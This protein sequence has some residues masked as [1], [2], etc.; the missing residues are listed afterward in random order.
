MVRMGRWNGVLAAALALVQN[1][2]PAALRAQDDRAQAQLKA[3]HER[4]TQFRERGE[5]KKASDLYEQKVKLAIKTFG[6]DHPE[7]ATSLNNLAS[8]YEAQGRYAEA[9]PLYQRSL[10][11][12]EAKLGPDHPDVATSLN[13]LASLYEKQGRYAEAEPLYK[14]SL[15]I[16]EAKLGPDHPDVATSLNNLAALYHV[17]GPVCGG[18]AALPAQPQDPGSEARARPPR[19]RHQPEQP[20]GPVPITGPVCGGRAALQ[21]QPRDPGGEARARPP[22]RGHQPEQPGGTV[23]QQ[24]RYAE[25]EPLYKRSLKIRE[26]KLGPDHPDVATSLNNWRACTKSRAGMRRPSRSTNAASRSMK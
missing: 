20:G 8:L 4:A 24:G 22:R 25:A 12:K 23:P 17:A 14:R 26:A 16:C 18:R 1:G 9:E 21:T 11:I 5:Y 13:N 3:L 10:K 7:V 15:E 2:W 6:P 19:C